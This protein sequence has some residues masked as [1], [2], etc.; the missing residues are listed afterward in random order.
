MTK[1]QDE[2]RLNNKLLGIAKRLVPLTLL[3]LIAGLITNIWFHMWWAY[4]PVLVLCIILNVLSWGSG[5]ISRQIIRFTHRH[6]PKQ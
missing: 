1:K 4:V 2:I 3:C 6:Q 5:W